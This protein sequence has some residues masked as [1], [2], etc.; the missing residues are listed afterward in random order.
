MGRGSVQPA[1]KKRFSAALALIQLLL[2]ILQLHLWLRARSPRAEEREREH[3]SAFNLIG[4][5]QKVLAAPQ[6]F[7]GGSEIKV[8]ILAEGVPVFPD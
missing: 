7:G 5:K 4:V 6:N 8:W 3:S 1:L 2:R